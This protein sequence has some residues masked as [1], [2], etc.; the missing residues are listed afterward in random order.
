MKTQR[1]VAL[2]LRSFVGCAALSVSAG[3]SVVACGSDDDDDG[4]GAGAESGAGGSTGGGS[5]RGGGAGSGTGG[6]AGKG[7]SGGGDSGSGGSGNS[8]AGQAGGGIGGTPDGSSGAGASTGESGRAGNTS[9]GGSAGTDS[10]SAGESGAGGS[11][12]SEGGGTIEGCF[13]GLRALEGT[14]QISTRENAGEQIRLRLALET[15]DRIGTSGTY[16]WAPVRLALEIDGILICLDESALASAYAGTHHNCTDTL[17]F[18]YDGR[19][20]EI[21]SPDSRGLE[22]ATLT[23]SSGGSVV[24]GPLTL[25]ATEC[26]SEGGVSSECRSGGPC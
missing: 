12:G 4:G 20:Y 17:S 23:V 2:V 5:G 15:A 10:G 6:N 3:V 8:E 21:G 19:S 16:P 22:D 24:R 13:E 26:V 11:G 9:A 18:E 25:T 14:S 1:S 7:G